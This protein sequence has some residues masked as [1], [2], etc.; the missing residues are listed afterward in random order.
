[1][2]TANSNADISIPER[3][4][5]PI[6]YMIFL[7]PVIASDGRTYERDCIKKWMET[8]YN[9]S[10]FTNARLRE[11]VYDNIVLR[12]EIDEWISSHPTQKEQQY[13]PVKTENIIDQE[14]VINFNDLYPPRI[15]D[16]RDVD[17]SALNLNPPKIDWRDLANVDVS[18]LMTPKIDWRDLKNVE[19]NT[20]YNILK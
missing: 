19:L 2:N 1:M 20:F 3:F 15:I 4:I 17:V 7:D 16:W 11:Q 8:N 12:N 10:P 9:R 13:K 5:C 18:A 6:S 14:G